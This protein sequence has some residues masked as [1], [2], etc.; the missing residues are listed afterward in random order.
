MASDV[1]LLALLVAGLALQVAAGL[2]ARRRGEPAWVAIAAA[3]VVVVLGESAL[4]ILGWGRDLDPLGDGGELV[5]LSLLACGELYVV[6][7][8][9][10]WIAQ[11]TVHAVSARRAQ[12]GTSARPK[13]TAAA[14]AG[15]PSA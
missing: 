5:W 10:V 1:I 2:R 11:L 7:G 3:T 14:G 9:I 13:D 12:A 6:T 4:L 15:R 8:A